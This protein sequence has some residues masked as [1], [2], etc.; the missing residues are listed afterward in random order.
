MDFIEKRYNNT[1]EVENLKKQIEDL[2][3]D[4]EIN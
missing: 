2:K 3:I 1:S 4:S